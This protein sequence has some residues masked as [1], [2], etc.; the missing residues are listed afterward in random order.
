MSI[1]Q[2]LKDTD[3]H[4]EKKFFGYL[5]LIAIAVGAFYLLDIALRKI[6]DFKYLLIDFMFPISIYLIVFIAIAFITEVAYQRTLDI[7]DEET[8]K[9]IHPIRIRV[10]L[11]TVF[12]FCWSFLM[13]DK[14]LNDQSQKVLVRITILIFT[15]APGFIAYLVS[16]KDR[17]ND[18]IEN[19][20]EEANQSKSM[21]Y[22]H[23]KYYSGYY[24]LLCLPFYLII[25]S[26]RLALNV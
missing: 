20:K 10:I 11:M 24:G 5:F 16:R 17:K 8:E 4:F 7:F 9:S 26:F 13:V 12:W 22:L 23:K 15:I 3:H 2:N 18:L 14:T 19:K 6:P 25:L 21:I 1:W